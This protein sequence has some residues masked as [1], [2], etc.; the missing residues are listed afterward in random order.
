MENPFYTIEDWKKAIRE[1]DRD[2]KW[3]DKMLGNWEDTNDYVHS[4]EE[5]EKS[6]AEGNITKGEAERLIRLRYKLNRRGEKV[7]D[8]REG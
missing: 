1:S 7:I 6:L 5:I 4:R 8:E 2:S 3:I